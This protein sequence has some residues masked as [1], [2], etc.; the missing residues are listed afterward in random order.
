MEATLEIGSRERSMVI[1]KWV[2]RVLTDP[3]AARLETEHLDDLGL[4]R[5]KYADLNNWAEIFASGANATAKHSRDRRF[6]L[7][8]PLSY[9]ERL[10]RP[11]EITNEAIIRMVS[12]E[13]PG[14]YV[15]HVGLVLEKEEVEEYRRPL[16]WSVAG[17]D[18]NRYAVYF[19]AFRT[20]EDIANGWEYANAL[21]F[22]SF[23][24]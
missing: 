22:E 24:L 1:E 13:P 15:Q 2:E 19:R 18:R 17:L 4:P 9:T 11:E 5:E 3:A 23:Q 6:L 8:I 12:D 10:L 21:Y 20:I 14:V 7:V 16:F